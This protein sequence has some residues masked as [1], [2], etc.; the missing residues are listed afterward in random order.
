MVQS[1]H[2]F[3]L[4]SGLCSSIIKMSNVHIYKYTLQNGFTV[5]STVCELPIKNEMYGEDYCSMEIARV[6]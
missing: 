5:N 6:K 3:L 2:I 4:Q 1:A